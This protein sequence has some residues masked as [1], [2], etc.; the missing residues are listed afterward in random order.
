M[1]LELKIPHDSNLS[2]LKALCPVMSSYIL[3]FINIGIYW[4][5]HHHMLHTAH[6]VNG[7][8][9]WANI[10]LL[11]WLSLLPFATGWMGENNFKLWPVVLYGFVLLMSGISYYI[12]SQLLIK[13]HGKESTL[14]IAVGKDKKGIISV[15]IYLTGI[16]FSFLNPIIGLSLYA[17]VAT[18]WFIPDK[19][20]ERKIK[21]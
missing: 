14:A 10:L 1:V 8:V 20:I 3:S 15:V 2:A 11:F 16:L 19:R 12:L 7:A 17:L 9:L 18:M 21:A 6:K 5:N 13:L 4:N